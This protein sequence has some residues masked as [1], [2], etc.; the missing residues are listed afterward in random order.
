MK[1]QKTTNSD[2]EMMPGSSIESLE[3][4]L[5]LRWP[6]KGDRLFQKCG[7][8]KNGAVF[9]KDA[10]SRHAHIWDGNMRAGAILV[11][12][13]EE[14][15]YECSILIY[16]VLF[17][18]R[19]AIE[20]AMKWVIRMYGCYSTVPIDGYEHHNLWKLWHL[21]KKI[22]VEVG[23]EDKAIPVVEQVIKDFHDLDSSGQTFR[24][25]KTKAGIPMALPDYPIDLP[26]LRDVMQG[27]A[28]FFNG[29]DA[30]LDEITCLY[31]EPL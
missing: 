31:S 4:A 18:Y 16:P 8:S 20:L 28:H 12:A 2:G 22:I 10:T 13:C 3:D 29:V 23:S 24:Y 14:D 27:L 17:N 30:Q 5:N 11:S 7:E 25:P 15:S 6:K 21:C 19:H 1:N 26:R 9:S